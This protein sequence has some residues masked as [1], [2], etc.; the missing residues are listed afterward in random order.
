MKYIYNLVKYVLI[1]CFMHISYLIFYQYTIHYI[2]ASKPQR[3]NPNKI[4]FFFY[5]YQSIYDFYTQRLWLI[6][7]K[8]NCKSIILYTGFIY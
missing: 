2:T 1:K 5:Y 8:H 4:Q 3:F 6:N 7:H